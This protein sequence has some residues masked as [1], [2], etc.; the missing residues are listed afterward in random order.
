M[1]NRMNTIWA[2]IITFMVVLLCALPSHA[3]NLRAFSLSQAQRQYQSGD[4]SNHLMNLGGINQIHGFAYDESSQDLIL[5]GSVKGDLEPVSLNELAVALRAVLVHKAW[6][7]VSIDKTLETRRSKAQTIR[8][9]G[10]IEKTKFGQDLLDADV[11]LKKMGL[12]T[13]SAE[14]WGVTS[15]FELLRQRWQKADLE[16]YVQSRFW[17]TSSDPVFASREGIAL[18]K[19]CDVGVEMRMLNAMSKG[20]H[21]VGHAADGDPMGKRFAQSMTTNYEELCLYHHE[22]RRIKSLFRLVGIA[23]GIHKLSQEFSSLINPN[24]DFWLKAYPVA[25]V[26]T[27]NSYPLMKREGPVDRNGELKTLQLDG[28]VELKALVLNLRDGV[29]SAFKEIVLRSRPRSWVVS[30]ELPITD[31]YIANMTDPYSAEETDD[32]IGDLSILKNIS[33]SFTGQILSD[34]TNSPV[35]ISSS[36]S[37]LPHSATQPNLGITSSFDTHYSQ[38][39]AIRNVSSGHQFMPPSYSSDIGG[40]ML[41][42]TASIE[43]SPKTQI[44]LAGGNFSFVV[45]G[46][47]ALLSPEA[48]DKFI[49]ALWAVYYSEQDPGISIDPIARGIDKHMVR[50]IGR[51]INSD[52]GRVMR[53]ADYVMKKWAVGTERPNMP[54]FRSPDDISGDNGVTYLASSRFWFVPKNMRFKQGGGLLL[55][56]DG[57]MTVQTEYLSANAERKADP[58]NEEF[59]RWFTEEYEE[60]S[61]K[62]PIYKELFDYAKMVSLAKYLKQ[63]GIPLFWFLMANKNRTLTEDSPGTVDALAKGSNYFKGLRIEGGV[64]LVSQGD[65][66]YDAEAAA[67]IQKAWSRR[68]ARVR[69]QA[70]SGPEYEPIKETSKPLFFELENQ[71]YTVVPQHS[72][73]S[74]RDRLGIR[75]QT[76]LA[77]RC[78]AEPGLEVVRYYNPK[79][80]AD[81]EFGNGWRLM[82]PYRI[83]AYGTDQ[84][85]FLN[86]TIPSQMS[87]RNL[88][89]GEEEVLRFSTD[90]YSISG[91]VPENLGNSQTVGLFIM[92]DASYRLADKLGNEFWFD[93]AGYLTDMIFSDDHRIHYDYNYMSVKDI[94]P[95]PFIVEP[96][97]ET[98]T[99]F[100]GL[101]LPSRIRVKNLVS[102]Y[103]ELFGLDVDGEYIEYIPEDIRTSAYKAL[104]LMSDASFQLICRHDNVIDFDPAGRFEDLVSNA[105]Q[106]LVK[107]MSVNE[108]QVDFVY[109][110]GAQGNMLISEARCT[111]LYPESNETY[112]ITY[113]YDRQERICSV[114][115]P[116]LKLANNLK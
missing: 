49:T 42:G 84:T 27:P 74:G 40:V 89:T 65:F 94:S 72:L 41:E 68:T 114:L 47:N 96:E 67:A 99:G 1:K 16:D 77:L 6:P 14:V 88:V 38:S 45:N 35:N 66:I 54:G 18:I 43:G 110:L 85:D 102:G 58:S 112:V 50:Y 70:D 53:E 29:V 17:F 107:S 26:Q 12:G 4:R 91:Y 62:Y 79:H 36:S 46:K 100:Q 51:V 11:V 60:I 86:V 59:A 23:A 95:N 24:I 81:G 90:R 21:L 108:Q 80:K 8:F 76:D 83:E 55:F 61:R 75:Y 20:N 106:R 97:G 22:I 30:W 44:N 57:R 115:R 78:G 39:A 13:I 113:Q 93:Q 63:K 32:G 3:D 25:S 15:Y 2:E 19:Q 10:G 104:V 87:V 56:D 73:T 52:L 103:S 28:G 82:V 64:D 111:G 116:G 48:F 33:C 71:T 98:T 69:R 5:V 34:G 101:L 37:S 92:T 109:S 7:M 31:T 9:G 105:A